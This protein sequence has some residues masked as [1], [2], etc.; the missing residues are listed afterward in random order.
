MPRRI[1]AMM[2][3][4][5]VCLLVP[6]GPAFVGAAPTAEAVNGPHCLVGESPLMYLGGGTAEQADLPGHRQLPAQDTAVPWSA[7]SRAVSSW[8]GVHP[9]SLSH[10]SPVAARY[11]TSAIAVALVRTARQS[12]TPVVNTGPTVE[13]LQIYRC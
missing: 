6:G 1:V 7:R 11:G 2:S 4:L 9:L 12:T 5:F 10:G 8:P 13:S 3:L